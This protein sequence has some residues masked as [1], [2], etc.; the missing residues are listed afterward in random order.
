VFRHIVL[1]QGVREAHVT[2][3]GAG[4]GAGA[5]AGT[6]NANNLSLNKSYFETSL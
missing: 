5:G 4:T 3:T 6:G 1:P 2:G